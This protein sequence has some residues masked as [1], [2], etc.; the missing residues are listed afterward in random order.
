MDPS[1]GPVYLLKADVS[2]EFYRIGLRPGDAPKLGLIFP[3][4]ADEEPIVAIPL[5]L[6]MG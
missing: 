2:D 1:L 5:K 3:N 6:P 4:S